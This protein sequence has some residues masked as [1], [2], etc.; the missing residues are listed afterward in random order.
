M[1][2]SRSLP[3]IECD[4]LAHSPKS[5]SLHRSLQKGRE[6]FSVVQACFFW[7]VGHKTFNFLEVDLTIL[8][9]AHPVGD[10]NYQLYCHYTVHGS[11][12]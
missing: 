11:Q 5:I 2:D 10:I 7:H 8:I 4:S 1:S 6:G 9:R 12:V 3:A